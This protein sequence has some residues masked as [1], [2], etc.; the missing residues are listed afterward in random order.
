M[1]RQMPI[2]PQP[3][4]LNPLKDMPKVEE[5]DYTADF[6]NLY[7]KV[8]DFKKFFKSGKISYRMLRYIPGLA[9]IGYL[10]Q[11]YSTETKRKYADDTCKNKK[12]IE[13]NI[14]LTKGH[15]TDFQN[16][17]LCF[18][19]K[20]K[21]A[22][23][24]NNNLAATIVTVNNFFAHWVKEI[25]IKRYSDD[26]L[27]PPLTNT[28]DVYRYSNEVLKHMPEKALKTIEKSLLYSKK[29]V[30]I[31]GGGDRRAHRTNDANAANRTDENL[32]DRI[33]KFTDQ[34]QNE[35]IYRIPL[36]VLCNVGLA[37]Q[38]FK[39]NT[40]YILTLETDMQ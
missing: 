17:H 27:I 18:L 11:L 3:L 31:R 23:D 34:L 7:L 10:G 37:N 5:V 15:Y 16:V 40:K 20:F 36:K 29:L 38:C 19:L 9:K 12:L 6:D 1:Q 39:F 28:V 30:V 33:A 25:D 24:N 26:I 22:A 21:S 8:D 32:T 13:F 2:L 14:Q 35:F 4:A